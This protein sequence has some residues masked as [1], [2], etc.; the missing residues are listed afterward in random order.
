M[1]SEVNNDLII[2]KFPVGRPL[3]KSYTCQPQ[4]LSLVEY[5]ESLV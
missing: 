5:G 3:P 4:E 2:I 1:I